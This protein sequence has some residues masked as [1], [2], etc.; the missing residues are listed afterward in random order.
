[1]HGDLPAGKFVVAAANCDVSIIDYVRIHAG[2]QV[3]VARC[4]VLNVSLTFQ[5][6]RGHIHGF[7]VGSQSDCDGLPTAPFAIPPPCGL[8]R[9]GLMDHWTR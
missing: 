1:M 5:P 8:R 2:A 3:A 9:G 4:A 7:R 6:I